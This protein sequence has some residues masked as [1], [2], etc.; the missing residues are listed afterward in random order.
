VTAL[1]RSPTVKL[2][3]RGMLPRGEFSSLSL[4]LKFLVGKHFRFLV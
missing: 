4:M 1:R 2:H 3:G